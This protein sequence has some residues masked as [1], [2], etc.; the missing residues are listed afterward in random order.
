M[1]RHAN[2]SDPGNIL[3]LFLR[4]NRERRLRIIRIYR[5]EPRLET[6]IAPPAERGS[7]TVIVNLYSFLWNKSGLR[8]IFHTYQQI[9]LRIHSKRKNRP[10]IIRHKSNLFICRRIAINTPHPL[11]TE[12]NIALTVLSHTVHILETSGQT[13]DITRNRL[14]LLLIPSNSQT[15]KLPREHLQTSIHILDSDISSLM[16]LRKVMNII[17]L[18][19]TTSPSADSARQRSIYP[20]HP[21]KIKVRK[22]QIL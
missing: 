2:P 15:S 21:E 13:D 17:K 16:H 20:N 12:I 10:R 18:Y 14:R 1:R 3:N 19:I 11:L 4:K 9:I 22:K 7:F 6:V 5:I 8:S